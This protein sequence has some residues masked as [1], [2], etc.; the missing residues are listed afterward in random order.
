[1]GECCDAPG[2]CETE[3]A[4]WLPI[5]P[6]IRF[7]VHVCAVLTC[8]GVVGLYMWCDILHDLC[9][10]I[11]FK[12]AI[13][14]FKVIKATIFG[15]ICCMYVFIDGTSTVK[16]MR[17]WIHIVCILRRCNHWRVT[18]YLRKRSFMSWTH[19]KD[20]LKP[21]ASICD[22]LLSSMTRGAT[23]FLWVSHHILEY[24]FEETVQHFSM[25]TLTSIV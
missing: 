11:R 10:S 24:K 6:Y 9:D 7:Q 25:I 22:W 8:V 14:Y 18:R 4:M 23:L 15:N 13:N 17:L 2:R 3:N 5:M 19:A 12:R 20:A 21:H 16:H 1:M